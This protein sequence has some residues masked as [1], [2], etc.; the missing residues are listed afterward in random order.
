MTKPIQ[1]ESPRGGKSSGDEVSGGSPGEPIEEAPV[2]ARIKYPCYKSFDPFIDVERLKSLDR[3]I[4]ERI[5]R[6]IAAQKDIQFYTGPYRLK[7]TAPD[8]PGSRMIYLAQ[9]RL[10]DSYFD[11]DK[12]DLWEPTEA[13]S[14]FSLLMDFIATL[15]FKAT[16]RMLIMYDDVRRP[17]PAHRDHTSSEMCHDFV[18]FRTN[19]NKPFYMLDHR[20]DEKLYV[21]SYSAWFDTVNQFHGTDPTDGLSFSIRVDG[22]FSDEFR[23]RIPVPA[24]NLASTPALWACT[25]G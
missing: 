22:I 17:V 19:L 6:H 7:G 10:P 8:R 2:D 23:K 5:S 12:T 9:S 18:W 13:T 21:E 3:Y 11:L 15:P 24:C 20:T 4:S 25:S 16:G 14:E 1:R